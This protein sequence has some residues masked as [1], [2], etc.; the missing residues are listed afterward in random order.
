VIKLFLGDQLCQF[1]AETQDF[2]SELMQLTAPENVI[3]VNLIMTELFS[4]ILA[5]V[6]MVY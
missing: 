2:C 3:I 6:F 5:S 4:D 1:R